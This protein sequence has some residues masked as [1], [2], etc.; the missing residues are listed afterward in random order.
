MSENSQQMPCLVTDRQGISVFYKERFLY[1]KY[2]PKKNITDFIA[3]KDFLPNTLILGFSPCLWYGTDELLKKIPEQCVIFAVEDDKNLF[4]LAKKTLDEKKYPSEQREKIILTTSEKI[5]EEIKNVS[6]FRRVVSFD[7]S[8]GAFFCREKYDRLKLLTE[9]IISSFW[10]NRITL[11]KLGRLFSRNFVRNLRHS[12]RSYSIPLRSALF[13][14]PIFVFGAGESAEEYC[15][16]DFKDCLKKFTVI[17]VDAALPVLVK[18]NIQPD[19]FVAVESQLA[20]EKAYTGI[21]TTAAGI[22]D[23]ASRASIVNRFAGRRLF[24]YSQYA[25]LRFIKKLEN[26]NLLPKSLPPLGSVGLTAVA[27]ALLMRESPSVPVFFAGMDFSYSTGKTHARGTPALTERLLRNNRLVSAENFY[28]AFKT[29]ARIEEGKSSK[30]ITDATLS[31]Y[32]NLFA[33]YF[34]GAA[35]LFDAGATGLNLGLPGIQKEQIALLSN[36]YRQKSKNEYDSLFDEKTDLKT[37]TADF[38]KE[39]TGALKRIRTLLTDGENSVPRPEPSLDAELKRLLLPRDYLYIHFP[40][41]FKDDFC[42]ISFLK[43]IRTELDFFIKDFE[44]YAAE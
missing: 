40:D 33:D 19:F 38:I 22:F 30:V 6:D 3:E 12:P 11:V 42:D 32:K 31:G 20:I 23:M 39:E 16:A 14:R 9:N 36:Q 8:G 26:L 10:K 27:I 44:E 24:F 18:N 1:S 25:D 43:R 35:N 37:E 34:S 41:G 7:F 15:S 2:A 28:S 13:S 17:C 4:D 5:I 29:G 21:K